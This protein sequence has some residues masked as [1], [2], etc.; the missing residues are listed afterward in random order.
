MDQLGYRQHPTGEPCRDDPRRPGDAGNRSDDIA[1]RCRLPDS[2]GPQ[3]SAEPVGV[4]QQRSGRTD[5]PPV[6]CGVPIDRIPCRVGG[7][8]P[9]HA[10]AVR[11]D[12]RCKFRGASGRYR[13][14]WCGPLQAIGYDAFCDHHRCAE[15][16]FGFRNDPDRGGDIYRGSHHHQIGDSDGGGSAQSVRHDDRC[17][18]RDRNLSFTP[19]SVLQFNNLA[20]VNASQPLF[21]AGANFIAVQNSVLAGSAPSVV[22]VPVRLDFAGPRSQ[23]GDRRS[24]PTRCSAAIRG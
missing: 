16:R 22:D 1:R 6:G 13:P 11:R 21:V 10:P 5:L 2:R 17:G 20:V 19:G 3:R 18:G 4:V 14:R 15:C 12:G 23:C 9:S 24:F 8:V 7:D